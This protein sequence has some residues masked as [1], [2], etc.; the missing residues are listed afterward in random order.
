MKLLITL[1]LVLLNSLIF[2]VNLT[3]E[4]VGQK[5]YLS[6]R[7][8]SNELIAKKSSVDYYALLDVMDKNDKI[9]YYS[10]ID[11]K[12]EVKA[13]EDF[14]NLLLKFDSALDKGEYSAY[15]KVKSRSRK[16]MINEKFTFSVGKEKSATQLIIAKKIGDVLFEANDYSNFTEDDTYLIQEY[17]KTPEEISLIVESDG[18]NI[19]NKLTPDSTLMVSLKELSFLEDYSSIYTEVIIDEKAQYYNLKKV[20]GLHKFQRMY[21]WKEQLEQIRYIV[22]QSE[23]RKINENS[24]LDDK[25][26]VIQFWN[27]L[28]PKA[29][30]GKN[31]LQEIFYN[32]IF[33]VDRKFSVNKYKRGWETDRGRIFIKYGEPDEIEVDNYPIGKFPTQTWI[34]YAKQKTF[35]FYDRSRMDDYILYNKEEEY[36]Y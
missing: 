22:N 29:S 8:N 18:N 31:S 33:E 36:E 20:E 14:G 5:S 2:G 6:F 34:Y 9:V 12:Y 11:I 28:N 21:T 30:Q 15:L 4:T 3:V 13:I 32:R 25:D 35:Y 7:F 1:I 26:R 17:I 19:V 10:K 23:W 27:R 16:D 24:D